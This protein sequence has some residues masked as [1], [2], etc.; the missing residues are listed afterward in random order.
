MKPRKK[1]TDLLIHGLLPIVASMRPNTH[2]N[3]SKQSTL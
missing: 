2:K 1:N 3:F